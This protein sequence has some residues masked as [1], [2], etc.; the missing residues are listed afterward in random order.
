MRLVCLDLEGVLVPEIWIAVAHKSGIAELTRT[1]RDEPNY[2]TLMRYRLDILAE[3]GLGFNDIVPILEQIEPLDG[4]LAFVE[5]LREACQ[6]IILSDTFTQFAGPIMRRLGWPT[7]FCNELVVAADGRITDWRLRQPDGKR[8]AVEALRSIGLQ[9]FAVGD[10]YNDLS[11]IGAAE[12]GA[13]FR[14]PETIVA[15]NP[16]IPLF[17]AYSPLGDFLLS[18]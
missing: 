17:R 10:S 14:A 8:R 6:L 9:V 15:A 12:R 16:N 11:M 7:L 3:Q 2:D 1:T 4:A 5:R 18:D 13:L